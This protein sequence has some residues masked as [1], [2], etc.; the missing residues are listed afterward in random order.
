MN[1]KDSLTPEMTKILEIC[2][3]ASKDLKVDTIPKR[4]VEIVFN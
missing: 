4:V 2:I 1:V 3:D